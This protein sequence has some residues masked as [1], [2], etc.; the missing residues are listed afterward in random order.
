[1]KCD[2]RSKFSNLSNWREEAWKKSGLQR[3]SNPW[4]PRYRCDA[5][6]TELW[7][8]TLGARSIYWVHIFPYSEMMWRSLSWMSFDYYKDVISAHNE[9]TALQY[10]PLKELWFWQGH[11][12]PTITSKAKW[13]TSKISVHK[14]GECNLHI[15]CKP[16]N[17]YS[18]CVTPKTS[19][20]SYNVEKTKA[21]DIWMLRY[22]KHIHEL[23]SRNLL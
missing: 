7:S 11:I 16:K 6:P 15:N 18:V 22:M 2:H 5:L 23:K 12:H 3:D 17:K 1:M 13:H 19:F 10:F 4:P 14:Y 9:C 8:H 20:V 21:F